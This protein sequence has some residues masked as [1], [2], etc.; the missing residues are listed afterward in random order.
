VSHVLQLVEK[1]LRGESDQLGWLPGVHREVGRV[2]YLA[3]DTSTQVD[4][5]GEGGVCLF[6]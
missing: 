5:E 3:V 2:T 1:T 6:H 4:G